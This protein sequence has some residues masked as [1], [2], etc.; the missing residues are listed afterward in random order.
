MTERNVLNRIEY[1]EYLTDEIAYLYKC[2]GATFKSFEDF[3]KEK[4][5]E[6]I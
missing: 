3:I 4:Q 1:L 5:N 6:R 2:Q